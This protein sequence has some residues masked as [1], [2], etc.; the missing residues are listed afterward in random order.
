MLNAVIDWSLN[1]RFLVVAAALGFVVMGLIV[2]PQLPAFEVTEVTTTPETWPGPSC[3][4]AASIAGPGPTSQIGASASDRAEARSRSSA[5]SWSAISRV[6]PEGCGITTSNPCAAQS[7]GSRDR[8]SSRLSAF[9]PGTKT[10]IA[11]GIAEPV[12]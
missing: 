12:A 4:I 3:G 6:L 7:A 5:A 1:H 10:R 11:A 9:I 2:L 8:K